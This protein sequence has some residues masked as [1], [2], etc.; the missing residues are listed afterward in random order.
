MN[1]FTTGVFAL[2]TM[3][4]FSSQAQNTVEQGKKFIIYERFNSAK[5]VLQ[6]V[7]AA[8]PNNE[9]AIYWLGQAMIRSEESTAKDWADAK[10]LYQSKLSVSNSQLLMAGIGHVELLE[11]KLPDAKNHFEAAVSLSQGKNIA[12]LNAIGFANGNPDA[13]NGDALY[14]IDKLN[15]A[16]QI[17][18]FNDPDVL[19][20][21]GDAW[22][23]NDNGGEALNAYRRALEIAPNYARADYRIGKM[24]QSQGRGQESIFIEYF[25][26]AMASDPLFAPVYS[27]LFNYY[28][29]TDVTKAAQYFEKWKANSDV[30]NKT[31]YYTAALK[32]A[33]GFFLEAIN[34]ADDC[35][36]AE[37]DN[38]YPYLFGLKANAFNRLKDSIHAVESYAVYFKRQDPF[39][40]ATADYI[41][42]A[43]NLLKLPG[44]EAA[45]GSLVD[46]AVA[47][48][49]L[50]ANR[51]QYI[52]AIASVYET[53]KDYGNA[54]IWYKKIL[55]FKRN[56]LK[57][58]FYNVGYNYYRTTSFDSSISYFS[59]YAQ[60]FPEDILGHFMIG[61]A[62]WAID[63]TLE[64]GLPIAPFE[65][66]IQIGSADSIKY[67]P[68]LIYCYKYF[69]AYNANIKKDKPAALAFI[70]KILALDPNDAEALGNKEALLK[71][72]KT[73]PAAK[74]KPGT[75][76]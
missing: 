16:T 30:D 54:A 17:K 60:K 33:Q 11:G 43:K 3:I 48:D 42:Y 6:K 38:P 18:K 5:E 51:I 53:R 13:K 45:A 66:A 23:R 61:K 39:K 46:R 52:K 65:K 50:E 75:K 29:E 72:P 69:V 71:A 26:K 44:N 76:P 22:R 68:Q 10:A 7:V 12:V 28:Y 14:A 70:D 47:M 1:K 49:T 20:N 55:N 34:H 4:T 32:Y 35:I 64:L 24:Y 15:Q 36:K 73:Q 57:T 31:C 58:D 21:L 25:N 59:K 63:T 9:E 40:L 74:P 67:K 2:F 62:S 19:V 41:E 27:N 8:E 37:G 56:P